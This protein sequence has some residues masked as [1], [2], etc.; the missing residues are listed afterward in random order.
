MTLLQEAAA[1]ATELGKMG[2]GIGAGIVAIGAGMGIGRL[3]GTA[4][5]SM[6]RQPSA[7]NDIRGAMVLTAA[8]IEGVAIIG[9]IVC[10]LIV[11]LG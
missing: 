5:E 9:E 4:V 8:F 10:I 6:A 1:A 2:A 11:L 7:A 3:A